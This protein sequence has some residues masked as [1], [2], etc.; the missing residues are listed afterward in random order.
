MCTVML[1]LADYYANVQP[2]FA[3]AGKLSSVHC[4]SSLGNIDGVQPVNKPN[5][6]AVW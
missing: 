4:C 1:V 6:M 2:T 3:R 5:I